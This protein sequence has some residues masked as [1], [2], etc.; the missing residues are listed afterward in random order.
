MNAKI[1]LFT[2][3]SAL[4]VATGFYG[5]VGCSTSHPPAETPSPS[6]A[7][8]PGEGG[9]VPP[10]AGPAIPG[11]S[12]TPRDAAIATGP[13]FCDLPGAE[14][15]LTVPD[16]FCARE[17]TTAPITEP[18]VLRFA[19]NGDLF[20]A[21]PAESTPGG[22]SGGPG[23][24][25][26]LP[27]DNHDG[28]ADDVLRFA[29]APIKSAADCQAAETDPSSLACVHGLLFSDG[30]L[31]Y[32]R[33]DEVRRFPHTPGQRTAPLPAGELVATLGG[34]GS[35]QVR[36]THTL[37]RGKNGRIFVSRGRFEAGGCVASEMEKGAIFG[38]DIAATMP[39]TPVVVADG[40]RNPMFLRCQPGCG[41]CYAN[42]LSGDSWV[43]LG[44]REKLGLIEQNGHWGYP[45]CVARDIPAPM[46]TM[47]Q[48]HNV[49]VEQAAITLHDTP[50]GL[51]FDNGSFP[52]PYSFGV[53]MALHGEVG[54]WKGTGLSWLTTDPTTH[55]PT[56]TLRPFATGWGHGAK[57][58]GRAT[59]VA[60]A[61]DGRLFVGDDTSGRIF[62]IAPR[63]LSM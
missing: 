61:P 49:G 40:F 1:T 24:I 10:D 45:C 3:S 17:F 20:V 54:S 23:A 46:A 7:G 55:K 51:D 14:A 57:L 43:G 37:D 12:C 58:E 33:S 16:G 29:G 22:A 59:D 47:D 4:L 26:V 28:K 9:F 5:G 13:K 42:E 56:G 15:P 38:L 34:A 35:P 31:Y 52:A 6:E 36:W 30:Y 32:T 60:F 25:L 41:D 27:D 19:P 53:F 50:F 62:W 18:R 11:T 2:F 21:A 39:L 8:P 44:G 63:S 48:C